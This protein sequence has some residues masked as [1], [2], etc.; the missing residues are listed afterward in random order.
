[1]P[2]FACILTLL[3][4]VTISLAQTES[5]LAPSG[6][7]LRGENGAEIVAAGVLEA[8]PEG[9]V[10]LLYG[11][12][13]PILAAWDKFDL[14]LLKEDQPKIYFGYL[15]AKRF[16]R[17]FL[18][19]LGVYAD[20]VS[21][22]ETIIELNRELLKPRFYPLPQNINYLIEQ[23]PDVIRWKVRDTNRYAKIMR[24]Y[25]QQLEDFFRRI[26]PKESVIIDDQGNVH[27]KD[28]PTRVDLNRAETTT[29]KVLSV[30]ADTRR[31]PSRIGIEYLNEVTTFREDVTKLWLEMR[32]KIPNA[33]F[34][35]GNLNHQKL[36][37]LMDEAT[38]ALTALLNEEHLHQSNQQRLSDFY[39]FVYS[40]TPSF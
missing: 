30:L 1:M 24:D 23:E 29:G 39:L 32:A 28:R 2:T 5:S 20:I 19:K 8:R 36:P 35:Q 31:T 15:D 7:R 33:A 26:F 14:E 4:L 10:I 25:Q 13:T 9:A 18:L 38:I 16:N 6:I 3:S 37:S 40:H 27:F 11:R 22:E 21:F 17:P 12:S 34:N